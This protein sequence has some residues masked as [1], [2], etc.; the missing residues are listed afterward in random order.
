MNQAVSYSIRPMS[1]GA[2]LYEVRLTVARPDP[3]GQVI[4]MPAWIPGSYMIRD[5]AKHVVAIRA[6]SVKR[7]RC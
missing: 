4:E 6:E 2:H 5:Y 3:D 1:P 7:K